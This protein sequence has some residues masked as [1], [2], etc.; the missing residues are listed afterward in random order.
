MSYERTKQKYFKWTCYL[1]GAMIIFSVV[2]QIHQHYRRKALERELEIKKVYQ[3][4]QLPTKSSGEKD[5][6]GVNSDTSDSLEEAEMS[7][8]LFDK[9]THRTQGETSAELRTGG[10]EDSSVVSEE[11]GNIEIAGDETDLLEPGSTLAERFAETD[12]LLEEADA[13]IAE[14]MASI[15][16]GSAIVVNHLNSLSREEQRAFLEQARR[17]FIRQLPNDA[18][19]A[20]INTGW[21]MFLDVLTENGY[22][23]K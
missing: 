23:P 7:L 4:I 22:Q 14:G 17:D 6:S 3:T 2:T 1:L 5:K 21:Q 20:A 11:S 10:T 18:D 8:P 13:I 16:Q 15:G 9:E 19:P 12:A